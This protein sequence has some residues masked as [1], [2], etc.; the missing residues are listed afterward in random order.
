MGI[1][2]LALALLA[3]PLASGIVKWLLRRVRR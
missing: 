1:A 3:I 2:T